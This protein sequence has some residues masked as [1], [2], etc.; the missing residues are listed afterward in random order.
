MSVR[1]GDVEWG[2]SLEQFRLRLHERIAAAIRP[3]EVMEVDEWAD[4]YRVLNK[5]AGAVGG[6][7]RTADVEIARGPMR[8]I[9]ESASRPS[10]TPRRSRPPSFA[11][12]Q[13]PRRAHSGKGLAWVSARPRDDHSNVTL[14][15]FPSYKGG[16]EL[17]NCF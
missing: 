2:D 4:T 5:E 12:N 1:T 15:G 7:F 3:P 9:M 11:P 13:R 14:A 6:R 17:S 16:Q 10:P 8:A